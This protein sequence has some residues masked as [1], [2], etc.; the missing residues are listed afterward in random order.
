M[1]DSANIFIS[2]IGLLFFYFFVGRTVASHTLFGRTFAA[3]GLFSITTAVSIW[4]FV[5]LV[6]LNWGMPLNV[7]WWVYVGIMVVMYVLLLASRFDKLPRENTLTLPI[8]GFI[9]LF[10]AF[11]FVWQDAPQT[12]EEL[13]VQLPFI[14]SFAS[15]EYLNIYSPHTHFALGVLT[16]PLSFIFENIESAFAILNVVLL[17]FVADGMLKATDIQ[18]RWSNLALLAVGGLLGITV[19]NPFF[20]VEALTAFNPH[21]LL[22]VFI[23][24]FMI[25]LCREKPLPFGYGVI[26]LSFI[27][28][29]IAVGFG[30]SG[31]FAA[32]SLGSLFLLRSFFDKKTW[33]EYIFGLLFIFCIPLLMYF[34]YMALWGTFSQSEFVIN[35]KPLELLWLAILLVVFLIQAFTKQNFIQNFFIKS[36][37]ITQ[38]ALFLIACL[39]LFK[40][41]SHIQH[42]QFVALIPIW[43][44]VTSWYKNSSWRNFAYENPWLIA[45]G[46][47]I[48]F[49]A[50]QTFAANTLTQRYDDPDLHVLQIA[51]ELP[52]EGIQKTDSI[53]VIE[54]N[55]R[56]SSAYYTAL[57]SYALKDHQAPVLNVDEIFRKSV[58]D[59]DLFHMNLLNNNFKY[60]WLHTPKTEDKKWV[61]RFLKHDRSYLFEINKSGLR[62][63]QIY[64]HPSY[65][66]DDVIQ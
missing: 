14:Q 4:A 37:W 39:V 52:K 10:P 22:S 20:N 31:L 66:Y 5:A 58:Q 30:E 16:Y 9:I 40:N 28:G 41:H 26:P 47:M 2:L 23:L 56:N 61:G 25:P 60:L 55:A 49:G 24:A 32:M 34:L 27:L 51:K 15:G 35:Y 7:L 3:S 50:L 57:L 8:M 45:F 42:I 54:H 46:L 44:L 48:V 53:A 62:L 21:L 18:V 6:G 13:T 63:I 17:A 36:A 38:P 43:Y 29:F 11:Y 64:P 59:I 65:V 1:T 19:L 33:F 12:I